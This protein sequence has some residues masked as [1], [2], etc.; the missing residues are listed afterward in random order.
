M[1]DKVENVNM[2]LIS[3]G[4]GDSSTYTCVLSFVSFSVVLNR[5]RLA[6]PDD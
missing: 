6:G 2:G 4:N 5:M 1:V 3:L